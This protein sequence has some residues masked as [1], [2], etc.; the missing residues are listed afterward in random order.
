[1]RKALSVAV[2]VVVAMAAALP[3]QA[4][5]EGT[6]FIDGPGISGGAGGS[7]GG[8]SIRMDGSDG[9][10]YPVLAGMLEPGRYLTVR[11]DGD[12]GPRYEAR[13][14]ITAPKGQPDVTQHLY[15]FAEGGPVLYTP[16]GQKFVMSATGEAP[17]GWYDAPP[18][19]IRELHL[20]GLPTTCGLPT[21][22]PAVT[23]PTDGT[24]ATPSSGPGPSPV[25][26]G[27][28]FLAGLLVAGAVA[29]RK[30]AAVRRAT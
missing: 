3:A 18:K 22:S 9:A 28:A 6:A 27:L 15:P 12:L 24:A 2:G 30:R 10:G 20:R 13:L 11:P 25:V 4:K 5:I 1:M 8:G 14:V 23:S 19:L 21:T 7:G 29:G 26:W 16:P 17:R